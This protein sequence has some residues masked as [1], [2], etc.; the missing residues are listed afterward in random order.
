MI[1]ILTEGITDVEFI[2]GLKG[3]DNLER[4]RSKAD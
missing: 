4:A 1:V 2:A 3:I